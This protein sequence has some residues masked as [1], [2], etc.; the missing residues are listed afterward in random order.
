[1]LLL[2]LGLIVL[3]Q[4]TNASIA[5]FEVKLLKKSDFEMVDSIETIKFCLRPFVELSIIH[6]ECPLGQRI[7]RKNDFLTFTTIQIPLPPRIHVWQGGYALLVN[8]TFTNRA[9]LQLRTIGNL[10]GYGEWKDTQLREINENVYLKGSTRLICTSGFYGPRCSR[11]CLETEKYKCSPD[12]IKVCTPEWTGDQCEKAFCPSGCNNGT[13]SLPGKCRCDP[14]FSGEKCDQCKPVSGCAHGKC[15]NGQP[16][17]CQCEKGWSGPLCDYDLEYCTRNEPCENGGLCRNEGPKQFTCECPPGYSGQKCEIPVANPCLVEGIC[18]NGGK[19]SSPA[20]GAYKCDC[21]NGFSGE[22]C[23]IANFQPTIN[24]CLLNP[25]QNGATC[26][27]IAEMAK[28]RCLQGFYGRFC[29]LQSESEKSI[30]ELSAVTLTPAIVIIWIAAFLVLSIS[31]YSLCKLACKRGKFYSKQNC[32]NAARSR[33]YKALPG[34]KEIHP[35]H[36]QLSKSDPEKA[37][38]DFSS[39][40]RYSTTPRRIDGKNLANHQLIPEIPDES[41]IYSEIVHSPRK[42][43]ETLENDPEISMICKKIPL[44]FA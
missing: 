31:I 44:R 42:T 16:N 25:C 41:V 5:T 22:H 32:L 17:T 10:S 4:V 18:S 39:E 27:E 14:G 33:I 34:N 35:E 13:C 3:L 24:P 30:D 37:G 9:T 26:L 7:I 6:E 40:V 1:M 36:N 38:S 23:Q 8:V 19:C 28:C 29:E 15:A 21:P 12:G 11:R 20:P 2:R 43:R